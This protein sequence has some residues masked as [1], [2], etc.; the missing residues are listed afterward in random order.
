MSAFLYP[1]SG[2]ESINYSMDR[3]WR[4]DQ[5]KKNFL[6]VPLVADMLK[7]TTRCQTRV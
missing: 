7:V 6:R 2:K 3:G 1:T 5:P 4:T